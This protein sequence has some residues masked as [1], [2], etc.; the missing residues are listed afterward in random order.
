MRSG[1][2]VPR[3]RHGRGRWTYPWSRSLGGGSCMGRQLGPCGCAV[4]G[5]MPTPKA[6]HWPSAGRNGVKGGWRRL[7]HLTGRARARPGVRSLGSVVR[8]VGRRWWARPSSP[9]RAFPRQPNR[10]GSRWHEGTLVGTPRHTRQGLVC[11]TEGRRWLFCVPVRATPAP[12]PAD[13][14]ANRLWGTR[15]EP[16]EDATAGGERRPTSID[17]SA[18]TPCSVR[19]SSNQ[20]LK[21]PAARSG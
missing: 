2:K 5:C 10:G 19:G 17:Q 13:G 16:R 20:V 1:P 18:V 8:S 12:T 4:G 3:A 11:P 15:L 14:G 6:T 21:R 7:S 9:A